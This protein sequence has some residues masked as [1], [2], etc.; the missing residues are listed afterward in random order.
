MCVCGEEVARHFTQSCLQLSQGS[1]LSAL[2]WVLFLACFV[3]NRRTC[4]YTLWLAVAVGKS[5]CR[6]GTGGLE[7]GGNRCQG[8]KVNIRPGEW[9]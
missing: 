7:K 6:E 3:R 4:V 1:V 5:L 8:T 2:C 9:W